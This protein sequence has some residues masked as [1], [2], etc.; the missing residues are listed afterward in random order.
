MDND[1]EE[2]DQ[3]VCATTVLMH[4]YYL[5]FIHKEPCMTSTQTGH[6]WLIE[7]LG[8]NVNRCFN[9]FRMNSDV[10]L[11]LCHRFRRKLW[12]KEFKENMWR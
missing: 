10:F 7:I 3:L 8:G 9:M 6:K 1:E 12:V 4:H 11:R 2:F 5:T